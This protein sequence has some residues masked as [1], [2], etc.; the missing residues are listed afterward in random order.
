MERMELLQFFFW[1]AGNENDETVLIIYL[2]VVSK[3]TMYRNHYRYRYF[4]R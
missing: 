2:P 3:G 4:L 1:V